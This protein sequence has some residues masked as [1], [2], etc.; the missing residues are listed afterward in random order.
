MR[1]WVS[2]LFTLASTCSSLVG[3]NS[4]EAAA[5][6]VPYLPHSAIRQPPLSLLHQLSDVV[7]MAGIRWLLWLVART[8]D[9]PMSRK[10]VYTFR[11]WR[12]L[13]CIVLCLAANY[14]FG[15]GGVVLVALAL[16]DLEFP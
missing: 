3:G 7:G 14:E 11:P 9:L 2:P 15:F 5:R 1:S 13:Y 8:E 16:I 6:P 10:A 4:D 12:F